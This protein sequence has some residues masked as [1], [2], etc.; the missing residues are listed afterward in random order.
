MREKWIWKLPFS[1][2]L[3]NESNSP[4]LRCI[5]HNTV[6]LFK[7]KFLFVFLMHK[8]KCLKEKQVCFP[9]LHIC[10]AYGSESLM[11]GLA[12]WHVSAIAKDRWIK[13]KAVF[14]SRAAERVIKNTECLLSHS[15]QNTS[16]LW[17]KTHGHFIRPSQR[18][19]HSFWLKEKWNLQSKA[20]AWMIQTSLFLTVLF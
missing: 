10:W 20:V 19:W 9:R 15:V 11:P 18:E 3:V 5:F 14:D 1:I 16:S 8:L 2:S 17:W 4:D 7:V 13:I 12:T 6:T